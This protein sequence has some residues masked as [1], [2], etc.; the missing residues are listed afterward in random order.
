MVVVVHVDDGMA[1]DDRKPHSVRC[2]VGVATVHLNSGVST[3]LTRHTRSMWVATSVL[4][5]AVSITDDEQQRCV[6]PTPAHVEWHEVIN[7]APVNA[8]PS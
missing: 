6:Q 7:L 2:L 3:V 4:L 8:K 5:L 1:L